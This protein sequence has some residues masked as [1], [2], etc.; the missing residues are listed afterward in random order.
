MKGNSKIKTIK[1]EEARQ[2]SKS[3]GAKFVW[4]G[5]PLRISLTK[6]LGITPEQLLEFEPEEI[7]S[8][9]DAKLKLLN[10]DIFVCYHGITSA[11]VVKFLKEKKGVEGYSLK[12]GITAIV[13]ENY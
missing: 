8:M 9:P 5:Q 2:L 3:K 6:A 11:A 4:L 13:G 12:G 1:I 10:N 7:V